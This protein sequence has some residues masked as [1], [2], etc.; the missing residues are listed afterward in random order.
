MK[1]AKHTL[2]KRTLAVNA[3]VKGL[4]FPRGQQHR[5]HGDGTGFR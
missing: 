5:P 4:D 3:L 1:T 2:L